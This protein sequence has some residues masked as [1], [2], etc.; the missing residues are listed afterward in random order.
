MPKA[1][2]LE[3]FSAAVEAIYD[4]VLRPEHWREALRLIAQLTQS[5]KSTMGITDH[6]QV[7]T[8]H[9]FSYNI[10]EAFVDPYL[11][12]YAA[13]NPLIVGG[14]LLPVGEVYMLSTI[15]DEQEFLESRIYTEFFAPHGLRD[16]VSVH[17][18]KRGRRH[19]GLTVIRTDQQPRYGEED[20]RVVRLIAP[21]ICRAFAISDALDLRTLTSE[22]LE[23]TLDALSAGVFL[24]DRESRIVYMN[25]AAEHQVKTG[26]VLRVFGHR[27]CAVRQDVQAMLAQAISD[28]IAD[29]ATLE[30]GHAVAL[31]DDGGAGLIAT[32]LPLGRGQRRGVSG[33]F[34]ASVAIFVQ[35]PQAAPVWPGEAFAKLYGLTGGELRVLLAIAPGLGLKEAADILGIRE[36]TAKTHLQRIFAKTGTSR[37]TELLHLLKNTA[38]PLQR[39]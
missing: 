4:S 38:S 14:H 13:M 33:P 19:A 9:L 24:A 36:T 18:L 23:A 5:D 7:R 1:P 10:D 17:A 34:A 39:Q 12:K 29:E 11:N 2:S 21:H 28:A 25:R 26:N 31:P 15:V 32:I 6:G 22:A 16:F 8:T 37:Q 3:T 35:D 20:L 27:L 30:G